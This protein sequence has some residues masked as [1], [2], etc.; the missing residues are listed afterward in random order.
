[1]FDAFFIIGMQN[2]R[3]R[4][5]LKKGILQLLL[6]LIISSNVQKLLILMS[7]K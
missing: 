2:I 5:E 4:G 6:V 1:M 7:L 3:G